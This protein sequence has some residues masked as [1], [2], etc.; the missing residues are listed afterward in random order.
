VQEFLVQ[1][2][3]EKPIKYGARQSQLTAPIYAA[4]IWRET[5]SEDRGKCDGE[6]SED[7]LR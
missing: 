4:P 7:P 6:L 1:D 2:S 3:S 5:I